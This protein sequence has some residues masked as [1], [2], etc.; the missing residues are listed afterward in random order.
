[1]VLGAYVGSIIPGPGTIIGAGVGRL[2]GRYNQEQENKNGK[3]IATPSFWNKDTLL[4]AFIGSTVARWPPLPCYSPATSRFFLAHRW[5]LRSVLARR[6]RRWEAWSAVSCSA[7][8]SAAN[9]AKRA[10]STNMKKPNTS[11]S[12]IISAIPSRPKSRR[13]SNTA[14]S[15]T[16]QWGKKLLEEKLLAGR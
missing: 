9:P 6:W 7:P 12:S 15:T 14:W 8:M 4:G 1:M 10:C 3:A 11:K 13:L 5:P 16:K 2:I